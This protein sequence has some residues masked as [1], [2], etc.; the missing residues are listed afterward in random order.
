MIYDSPHVTV[1][2]TYVPPSERDGLEGGAPMTLD[3]FCSQLADTYRTGDRIADAAYALT[4]CMTGDRLTAT[5]PTSHRDSMV[6][7]LRNSAKKLED[8]EFRS[9]LNGY[10]DKLGVTNRKEFL[11]SYQFGNTLE[12]AAGDDSSGVSYMAAA[13]LCM[14]AEKDE[15]LR[16]TLYDMRLSTDTEKNIRFKTLLGRGLAQAGTLYGSEDAPM[17]DNEATAYLGLIEDIASFDP[18]RIDEYKATVDELLGEGHEARNVYRIDNR[19]AVVREVSGFVRELAAEMGDEERAA[20]EAALHTAVDHLFVDLADK[21]PIK[22]Y[23]LRR[24]LI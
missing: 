11:N 23:A 13:Q 18:E 21:D 8:T 6:L 2:T 3:G 17:V 12:G 5:D 22:A 7:G 10:M 14:A 15:V 20:T 9:F 1:E 4:A 19:M 16:D 24:E